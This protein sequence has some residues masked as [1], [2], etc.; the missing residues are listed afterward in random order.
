MSELIAFL[1]VAALVIVT[2]GQD[3]AL[4]IAPPCWEGAAPVSS[5]SRASRRA[6]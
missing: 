1:G 4:T 3:A 5:P 2:R 6:S